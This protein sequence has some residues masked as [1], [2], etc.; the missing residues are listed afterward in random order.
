[1]T[2]RNKFKAVEYFL[3]QTLETEYIEEKEFMM[4]IIESKYFN[5]LDNNDK[6]Y[7]KMGIG[8]P[9]DLMLTPIEIYTLYPEN[10]Y[11]F[12]YEQVLDL[13]QNKRYVGIF[14]GYYAIE[15]PLDQILC[16]LAQRFSIDIIILERMIGSHQIVT[17]IL[18]TRPREKSFSHLTYT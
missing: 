4:Q 9:E 16:I 3:N 18:D 7:R 2:F 13:P 6:T 11:G 17:E 5:F 8:L 12:T 1:M 14:L 10:F 15:D